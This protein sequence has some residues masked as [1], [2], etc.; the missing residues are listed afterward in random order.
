MS[1]RYT[2]LFNE[3]IKYQDQKRLRR[4]RK[5]IDGPTSVETVVDGKPTLA[6]CSNDY[7]GLANHPAIKESLMDG[8]K[9]CGAG[10]GA[11]HLI[12]GHNITHNNFENKFTY[13]SEYCGRMSVFTFQYRLYGEFGCDYKPDIVFF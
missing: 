3:L 5:I 2:E 13:F 4:V 10:S 6:F 11:S 12:S 8:I 7:L 9:K 1:Q